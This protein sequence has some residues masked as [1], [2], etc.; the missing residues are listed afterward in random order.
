MKSTISLTIVASCVA[1]LAIAER[2]DAQKV[3]TTS[4]QFLKVMPTARATALGDAY[5]TL[6]TGADAVFWNPA[7]LAGNE[8]HEFSSTFTVWIFDSKQAALAYALPLGDVGTLGFQ[9][10][11]VNFG[12]IEETR[13]EYLGFVGS[14]SDLHYNPGYTGNTFSPLS[15]AVGLTFARELTDRFSTGLTAK[16]V[17]ESLWKDATVQVMNPNTGAL[18]TFNTAAH[19]FLFDF[20]MLYRTGFRSVDIGVSVQNLGASVKFAEEEYPAPLTFRL[21]TAFNALGPD[22][23]LL[24]DDLNRLT[25][26]VDLFQPNDYKQQVHMGLEY[27]FSETVFLRTGY[28]HNY[29]SEKFTFGAGAQAEVA[30]IFAALDYSYGLL[31]YSLGSVHRISLGVRFR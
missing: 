28:K 4:L 7:G 10:Q 15:Y 11:Y 31:S 27:A 26:A 5:S 29:D 8:Y 16:Y 25:V 21:G 20:G 30:G 14:G 13:T 24:L 2:A 9:L 1:L 6:A 17:S 12:E 22:A 3:G 23:L 18:E 19:V